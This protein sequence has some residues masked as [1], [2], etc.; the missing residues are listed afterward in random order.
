MHAELI[1]ALP[2]DTT[3]GLVSDHH[4]RLINIKSKNRYPEPL[5][6]VTYI[7]PETSKN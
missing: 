5:R 1:Q 4:V 3:I 6:C 2:V 7:D